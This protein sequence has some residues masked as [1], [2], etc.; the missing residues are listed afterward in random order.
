M[1]MSAYN[2]W[3]GCYAE[4]GFAPFPLREALAQLTCY[5]VQLHGNLKGKKIKAEQ[6]LIPPRPDDRRPDQK[7]ADAEA[8]MLTALAEF[9]VK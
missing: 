1:T 8:D 7:A 6:F 3:A 5:T 2:E 9:G 4:T